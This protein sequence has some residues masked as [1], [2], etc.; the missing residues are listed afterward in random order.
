MA[1]LVQPL[2][3]VVAAPGDVATETAS[4]VRVA[5]ELDRSVALDRRLTLQVWHWKTD[6]FPGL[7]MDGA[8]GICDSVLRIED[9][10][11]LV[12]IFWSRFGTPTTDGM[13]G[14]EHEIQKA[15]TTWR[16][17]KRPQVMV[18]FNQEAPKLRSSADRRQWVAVAEYRERFS[19]EGFC[20]EYD[21]SSTFADQFRI[22]LTN[23]LRDT[24]PLSPPGRGL[25]L[26]IRP[27]LTSSPETPPDW[28]NISIDGNIRL[29]QIPEILT[30]IAEFS[31]ACGGLGIELK[32]TGSSVGRP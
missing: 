6:A 17:N 15:I 24:F 8:Q 18:F 31:R 23:Y 11:V 30:A 1:D 25:S 28:L 7:H 13:T 21:G 2:K 4:V 3:I 32:L 20:W 14:T 22:C 12:G 16:N 29:A 26:A 27:V 9:C 19:S 10:D 5:S